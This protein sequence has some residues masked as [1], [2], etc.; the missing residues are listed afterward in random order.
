MEFR[1]NSRQTM[2]EAIRELGTEACILGCTEIELL[3]QQAH[4]PDVMVLPSAENSYPN[5]CRRPP[6][7]NGVGRGSATRVV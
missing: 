2:V 4:V 5:N 6:R 3:V 1:P 7:Q